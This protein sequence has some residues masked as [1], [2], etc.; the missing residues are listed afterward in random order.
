MS[1]GVQ[2]LKQAIQADGRLI[3]APVLIRGSF[4]LASV[5]ADEVVAVSAEQDLKCVSAQVTFG[6]FMLGSPTVHPVI[7]PALISQY[8]LGS[9]GFPEGDST[10]QRAAWVTS[11]ERISGLARHGGPA[12]ADAIQPTTPPPIALVDA[13]VGIPLIRPFAGVGL[14]IYSHVFMDHVT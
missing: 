3:G 7:R 4:A 14:V 10:T 8:P 11:F 13:V 6:S 5:P 9:T 1:A 2:A 12:D